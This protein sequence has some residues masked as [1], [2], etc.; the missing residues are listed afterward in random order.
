MERD[1]GRL[2]L[3]PRTLSLKV[4]CSTAELPT[5]TQIVPK[6]SAKVNLKLKKY[7]YPGSLGLR[8]PSRNG[9]GRSFESK[10]FVIVSDPSRCGRGGEA[11][12]S[13]G[14]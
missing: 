1:V 8:H 13:R 2:G 12:A 4:R 14:R 11:L 9:K 10:P 3:E 5:R 7:T 6:V